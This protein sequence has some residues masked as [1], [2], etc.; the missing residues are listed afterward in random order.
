MCCDVFNV[1]PKTDLLLPMWP[2]DAKRLDPPDHRRGQLWEGEHALSLGKGML[3]GRAGG[4]HGALQK[5][6]GFLR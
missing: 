6:R 2:R 5:Y 3:C 1:W 4:S